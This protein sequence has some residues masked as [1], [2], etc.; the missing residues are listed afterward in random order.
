MD[1]HYYQTWM[2]YQEDAYTLLTSWVDLWY[3]IPFIVFLIWALFALSLSL[4]LEMEN[5]NKL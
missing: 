3:E 1:F 5:F 4:S 2:I